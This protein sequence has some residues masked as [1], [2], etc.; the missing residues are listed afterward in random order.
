MDE[1][2]G[3]AGRVAAFDVCLFDEVCVDDAMNDL[4][5]RPF[6]RPRF[7]LRMAPARRVDLF[8]A[9]SYVNPERFFTGADKLVRPALA[10]MRCVSGS[11]SRQGHS[12][13]SGRERRSGVRQF[14]GKVTRHLMVWTVSEQRR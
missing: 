11:G 4:Q 6:N 1:G 2:D 13:Y 12:A 14:D 3:A 7:I 10:K 8:Q 9:A 5:Y